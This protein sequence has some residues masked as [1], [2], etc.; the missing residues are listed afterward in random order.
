[1]AKERWN[2]AEGERLTTENL[3]PDMSPVLAGWIM[4]TQD[5][6]LGGTRYD[7]DWRETTVLAQNCDNTEELEDE[8]MAAL[9]G[10]MW[11]S[12]SMAQQVAD[13]N[14][15]GEA[16]AAMLDK[17]SVEAALEARKR[18][19]EEAAI[20]E[21]RLGA[22]KNWGGRPADPVRKA[23]WSAL[24]ASLRARLMQAGQ[25]STIADHVAQFLRGTTALP[26]ARR[27]LDKPLCDT[28]AR[29]TARSAVVA[30]RRAKSLVD[31]QREHV[32]A[33]MLL[34]LGVA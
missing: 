25:A 34:K 15:F 23:N 28:L 26:D 8:R 19:E 17:R 13:K 21:G 4:E 5:F 14:G 29:E 10:Y 6:M 1:M 20:A 24:V 27:K 12:I 11:E 9:A 3:D 33:D 31:L 16:W 30:A 18:A 7:A 2:P 32:Y 22:E